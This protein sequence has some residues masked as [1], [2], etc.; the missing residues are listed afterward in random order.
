MA[1]LALLGGI[2]LASRA[3]AQAGPANIGP[4]THPVAASDIGICDGQGSCPIKHVVFIIKEN[5]SFDNLFAHFPGADGT[6]FARVR[7]KR[8]PLGTTPDH[9]PF[10]IAHTN[11]SARTAVNHGKMNQFYRLYGAVQFGHDYADSAYR[12][13]E[14]PNY[15][16]YASRFTLADHFFSTVLGPSFPNH[17][18]EIAAQSGG[19]IDNPHG[20]KNL[21]WGCDAIGNSLVRVETAPGTVIKEPPCFDLPTLADEANQA[22][23]SWR[24]YAAKPSNPGYIWAAFDAIRHIRYSPYWP[25]A[26]IPNR[27]FA[28]DVAAGRLSD[29]TWLTPD[30]ATSDHAPYSMCT[31]ENWT[32]AQIN[33]IM[34]SKFWKSTAIVLSWDDFGGFYDHVAPKSINPFVLGPRVPTI[35][36]SS[37]A[38]AHTI[39]HQLYDFSSTIRFAED[40]FGL[41]HL[42]EYDPSIP[43]I[44]GM[45]DFGQKPL[46]PM[47]LRPRTC[48]PYSGVYHGTG[49]LQSATLAAGRYKLRISVGGRLT[50]IT[51][52]PANQRVDVEG[53]TASPSDLRPG[54]RVRVTMI[55]DPTQAGAFVLRSLLDLNLLAVYPLQGTIVSIVTG[56]AGSATIT[57]LPSQ[58]DPIPAIVSP[59][60]TITLADGSNGTVNDLSAGMHVILSGVLD[61]QALVMPET[62]SVRVTT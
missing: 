61:T 35:V 51:Y 14:I 54:D 45:F 59:S 38:R 9:L 46:P 3:G 28:S 52:L 22:G 10:D 2:S 56:A 44:A 18:V 27:R 37:Y 21:S 12:K 43:S 11:Y 24:Y 4:G 23:V 31:G 36:I 62:S 34:R 55:P 16:A 47:I 17:L 58:G 57:V 20:Q 1:A 25:Q 7:G 13:S 39:T 32:V 6:S 40:V 49:T 50:A 15:W 29:I 60:T 33:A 48:P 41:S 26:D 5:H 8:V 19:A 42:P 53:G 30:A